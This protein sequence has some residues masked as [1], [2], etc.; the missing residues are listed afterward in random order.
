LPTKIEEDV[1]FDFVCQVD[2]DPTSA[3]PSGIAPSLI[4][5]AVR[6]TTRRDGRITLHRSDVVALLRADFPVS[7]VLVHSQGG[8]DTAWFAPLDA[9]VRNRLL[10]FL[11]SGAATHSLTPA[12]CRAWSDIRS[13]VRSAVVAGATEQEKLRAA[14]RQLGEALGD[15]RLEVRRGS[16]GA[17]TMVTAM[18]F[19]RTFSALDQAEEE[20][21]YVATF[22]AVDRKSERIASLALRRELVSALDDLPTPLI[23]AGFTQAD[24]CVLR[25]EGANGAADCE[26]I[27]TSNGEHVGWCRPN[28]FALTASRRRRRGDLWVHELASFADPEEAIDLGADRRLFDFLACC[29]PDAR[30][31][32]VGDDPLPFF[33]DQFSGLRECG[34]F[35]AYLRRA[36]TLS[37]WSPRAV[38]LNDAIDNETLETLAWLAALAERPSAVGQMTFTLGSDCRPDRPATFT[39]PVVANMARATVIA[40][41]ECEGHVLLGDDGRSL[42]GISIV[43]VNS[44]TIEIRDAT[45]KQTVHPEF[46]FDNQVVVARD[47]DGFAQVDVDEASLEASLLMKD[48]CVSVAV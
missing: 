20:A 6:T 22:G 33:V 12:D 40:W 34:W 42:V 46:I 36:E 39:V 29:T 7:I 28:G 35:A 47:S 44:V 45:A 37:G 3:A 14:E 13:W 41:L 43:R 23:L 25:V 15:V 18:D 32:E 38:A 2:E 21:L 8:Q 1:G 30:V 19:Y 17:V 5:V 27:K 4:G 11:A 48:V 16:N 24:N 9:D 26:F 10:E 31:G